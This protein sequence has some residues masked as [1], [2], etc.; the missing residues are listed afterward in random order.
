MVSAREK[1]IC[2]VEHRCRRLI[3]RELG[4]LMKSKIAEI[5]ERKMPEHMSNVCGETEESCLL[6]CHFSLSKE[7]A[8]TYRHENPIGQVSSS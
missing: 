7:R 6:V 2:I 3:Y 5:A 8:D 1:W 4:R